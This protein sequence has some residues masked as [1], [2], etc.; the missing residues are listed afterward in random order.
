MKWME[1]QREGGIML[2]F[3]NARK[4]LKLWNFNRLVGCRDD[5]RCNTT[6]TPT[7]M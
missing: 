1:M 2:F 3:R 7:V 6:S 4:E 5:W